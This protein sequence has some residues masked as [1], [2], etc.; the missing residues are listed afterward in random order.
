MKKALTAL[1]IV[2]LLGVFAPPVF[3]EEPFFLWEIDIPAVSPQ[4]RVVDCNF[5]LSASEEA[6]VEV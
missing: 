4:Y 3:A 1:L 2:V 6:W 5:Y